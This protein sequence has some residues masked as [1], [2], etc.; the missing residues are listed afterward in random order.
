MVNHLVFPQ[1][2]KEEEEE[3]EQRGRLWVCQGQLLAPP[4]P[5]A[6]E[7]S[8]QDIREVRQVKF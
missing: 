5:D 6:I 8:V 1:R 3:K 4:G 2:L 7:S